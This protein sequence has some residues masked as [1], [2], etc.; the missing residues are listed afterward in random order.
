[1]KRNI[2]QILVR[3]SLLILAFKFIYKEKGR[4]TVVLEETVL[5]PSSDQNK[6]VFEP[7]TFRNIGYVC[8]H[9]SHRPY[10]IPS[11]IIQYRS[12]GVKCYIKAKE[13]A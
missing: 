13:A 7:L 2:L 10:F 1:M 9:F 11:S 8:L 4:L 6:M 12:M 5:Q 3:G